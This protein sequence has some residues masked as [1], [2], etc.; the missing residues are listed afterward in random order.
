MKEKI[1]SKINEIVDYI[2]NKPIGD[3]TLDDYTI[4]TNELKN[5]QCAES[6]E[7]NNKR[8]AELLSMGFPSVGFSK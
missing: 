6:Q 4:L 2:V 5:I 8:M 3:V 7:A 1:E